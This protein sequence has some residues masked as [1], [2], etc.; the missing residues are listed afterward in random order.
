MPP[1]R[2][3]NGI[4]S[5]RRR[6]DDG[7]EEESFPGEVDDD[8]VSEGSVISPGDEDADG[9]GSDASGED[10]ESRPSPKTKEQA[11]VAKS[12]RIAQNGI[13]ALKPSTETE[14]VLNGLK[15]SATNDQ[16]DEIHFEDIAADDG[17]LAESIVEG[18]NGASK[19]DTTADKSRLDHQEY[20]RQRDTNPA[21]VPNRG[22]FF[23]HDDRSAPAHPNSFRAFGRGR[24]RG[25]QINGNQLG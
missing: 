5:R 23:L 8:S 16:P 13:A 21:F 1:I 9:E 11:V 7:E 4:P 22:G 3:K 17:T 20:L 18:Q 15:I 24:G 2:Q 12:S 19:Q 25:L 14:V 6:E 10:D